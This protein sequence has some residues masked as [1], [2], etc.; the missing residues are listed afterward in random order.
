MGRGA[1]GEGACGHGEVGRQTTRH[2]RLLLTAWVEDVVGCGVARAGLVH[3]QLL[4]LGVIRHGEAMGMLDGDR[5]GEVYGV[6]AKGDAR[7]L[8]ALLASS[9]GGEAKD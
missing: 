5:K 6:I 4:I 9:A 8:T 2:L 7:L 3:H 1:D